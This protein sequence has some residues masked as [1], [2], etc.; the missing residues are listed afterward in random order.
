LVSSH[1]VGFEVLTVVIMKSTIFWVIT[2]CS[3]LKVNP[4]FGGTYRLH[5]QGRVCHLLLRWFLAQLNFRPWRWRQYIPPKRR[6][7][8]N[9]LHGVISQEMVLFK[10]FCWNSIPETSTKLC[11]IIPI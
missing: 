4:R 8:L 5:L 6:L 11:W 7:T 3:P 9:G 1:F 10:R 2:P